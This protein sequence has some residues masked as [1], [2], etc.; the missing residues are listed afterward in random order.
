MS[1]TSKAKADKIKARLANYCCE[2]AE[3]LEAKKSWASAR[4]EA[5]EGLRWDDTSIWPHLIMARIDVEEGAL[6]QAFDRLLS[7]A[8][9][10]PSRVP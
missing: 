7:A 6:K 10:A 3:D 1:P 9:V 5:A 8:N 2:A 4:E